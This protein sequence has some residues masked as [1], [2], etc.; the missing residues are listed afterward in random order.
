MAR[1]YCAGPLFNPPERDEMSAIA[2]ILE[3]AGH[4]TFLPQR[5]G[6]ELGDVTR[7]L[8]RRG[9]LPGKATDVLHRAIF[10]LDVYHLL[11]S[12]AVV[13][14]LNGR[15]PDEGTAVEAAV[16]WHAGKALVLYKDDARSPFAG[17]DNP[18]LT[19]LTDLRITG[20]MASLPAAV[21]TALRRTSP[22]RGAD[23]SRTGERIA[24]FLAS[25][26]EDEALA[27]FLEREDLFKK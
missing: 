3:A 23:I 15:V 26:P 5:D 11:A 24:A 6:F 10:A 27:A 17:H 12:D 2:A 18:M 25:D 8:V 9:V 1:V 4:T 19:C 20:H 14:N 7:R 21:E 16:A 13:A 22:T